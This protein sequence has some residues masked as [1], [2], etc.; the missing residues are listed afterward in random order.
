MRFMIRPVILILLV[1][2]VGCS[3]GPKVQDG[4]ESIATQSVIRD[5][6]RVETFIP[7]EYDPETEGPIVTLL[8]AGEEPRQ[9]LR[10]Q[11]HDGYCD[12]MILDMTMSLKTKMS[13]ITLVDLSFPTT[14]MWA[15]TRVEDVARDGSCRYAAKY[16]QVEVLETEGVSAIVAAAYE[17]EIIKLAGMTS[18]GVVT[19]RGF[20]PKMSYELP[21]GTGAETKS[22]MEQM[23][24]SMKNVSAPLPEEEVGIGARWSVFMPISTN[25][26]SGT[27]TATFELLEVTGKAAHM[28][29]DLVQDFPEQ[30]VE[31]ADLPPGTVLKLT[32][33]DSSAEG[34][35]RVIY[36]KLIPQSTLLL[37][38]AMTMDLKVEAEE[39][40]RNMETNVKM[41][42]STF[43]PEDLQ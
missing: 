21:E 16:F 6:P 33:C 10:Y 4:D 35:T 8:S 39:T 28:K 9:S 29:V 43:G 24:Q 23:T 20:Q 34:F 7:Q 26:I 15:E 30:T 41:E 25:G 42:I 36:E 38:S 40:S 1:I 12:T 3:G 5:T 27:Q 13:D 14:R 18:A 19:A 17:T 31:S 37:N 11:F 22:S 32:G 2:L